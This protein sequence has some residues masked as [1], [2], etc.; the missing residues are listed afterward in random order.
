MQVFTPEP[1]AVFAAVFE[2]R[3]GVVLS[4]FWIPLPDPCACKGVCLA[5]RK[6]PR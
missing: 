5:P 3:D 2:N 4:S 1:P 6:G